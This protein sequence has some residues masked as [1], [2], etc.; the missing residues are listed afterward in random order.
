M[1][2]LKYLSQLRLEEM[3]RILPLLQAGSRVLEIGAGTGEQARFLSERG[4]DIVAIDLP[5][6]SYSANRVFPV[7]DYDGRNVPLEDDSIDITFSSNVLEHVEDIP[8]VLREFARVSR[9]GGLGIHVMP[10]PSWRFWTFITGIPTAALA[11][12]RIGPDLVRPPEG[13]RRRDAVLRNLKTV[14][15]ALLPIG[16]GTSFEGF[17]ELWTFSPKSW[18]RRFSQNEMTVA[19]ELPMGLFYTGHMLLGA[20]LSF[21]ARQS[22]SRLLGSSTRIYVVR[23]GRYDQTC[24]RRACWEGANSC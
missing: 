14:A 3:Q 12:V 5:N 21:G 13:I 19:K 1:F 6:S 18:R 11:L 8:A 23:Y 9:Q 17:S 10:T 20:R 16:H 22:L 4:F 2:N 15:G 7:V 24:P